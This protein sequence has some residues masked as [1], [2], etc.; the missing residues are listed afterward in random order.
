ML[1]ILTNCEGRVGVEAA[2]QVLERGGTALDSA[3]AGI[4]VVE[5]DESVD[6][7]GR[8]GTPDVLGVMACDA[9]LMDGTTLEAGAV[10]A[11][12]GFLHAVSVAREVMKRLPHVLLT[13][14]GAARFAYEVGAE[15]GEL[16]TEKAR[17]E[18]RQWV[19]TALDP[20]ER[21]QLAAGPLADAVWA[22]ARYV[23]NRG[24]VVF[25]CR[26]REGNLAAGAST[27]GWAYRY[28]GRLG[29]SPVVGAGLYADSRYGACGCTHAGE[30]TIRCATAR[31]VVQYLKS[32]MD[33]RAAC[34]EAI[35]D[36]RDLRGGYIGQVMVHA[37]DRDGTPCV[38]STHDL[39]E[40]RSAH[41]WRGGGEVEKVRAEVP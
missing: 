29:D 17:E 3:E 25:L 13:G 37:I 23:T 34:L 15:R 40:K 11:L 31:S 8:G 24:T 9:A 4:R 6:S 35:R 28:P 32:G 2:R 7:V 26:D 27:S 12:Q 14:E 21:K 33:V 16:L 18:Y 22:A 38:M 10:G 36:L 1:T 39:G 5:T 20:A 41:L 30:M 19:D